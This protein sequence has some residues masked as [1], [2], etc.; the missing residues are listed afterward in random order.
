VTFTL[1]ETTPAELAE[2]LAAVRNGQTFL[3]WRDGERA[4]QLLV[5]GRERVTVGRED[6]SDVP[7]VWDPEASRLHALLEYVG[8]SWTVVDDGMSRNGTFVNGVRVRS[9][10]RLNDG[11]ILRFGSTDVLIRDPSSA[12]RETVPASSAGGH[13]ALAVTAAQRRV[14]VILC[15]PL[16]ETADVA[17]VLPSNPE[18]ANEL[19]VSVEA[20]RSH[21]KTLF[22]LFE[23]PGLP[24][25]RKR[26]ELARRAIGAGIV[27][28][29]DRSIDGP[30][31]IRAP[32]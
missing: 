8:G 5:L 24:P 30:V 15:R 6:R 18:I 28:L 31:P 14:L 7:L 13:G 10:Q 27:T 17:G 26:A 20:V 32:R 19:T 4:Q 1:D 3:T 11:D 9:R 23:V 12:T 22:K 16:L 25:N 2:L 21:M 29:R